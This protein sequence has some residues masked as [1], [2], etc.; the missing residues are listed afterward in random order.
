MENTQGGFVDNF[1]NTRT[2]QVSQEGV[3]RGVIVVLQ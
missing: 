1:Q 2:V 3:E